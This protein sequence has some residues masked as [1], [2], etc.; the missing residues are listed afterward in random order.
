MIRKIIS[1]IF[2]NQTK[3][4]NNISILKNGFNQYKSIKLEKPIFIDNQAIPWYTY[5][6]IEYLMQFDYSDKKVLEFGSG[7]SSIFWSKRCKNL[8]S[9]EHNKDWY[10]T[11]KEKI[12]SNNSKLILTDENNYV[13]ICN[14]SD[15]FDIIIIDG[16]K[17]REC[18]EHVK[19]CIQTD[20]GIIILDNSDRYPKTSKFLRENLNLFEI[21]FFGFGPIN[22]YT[23]CT[24]IFISK[25]SKFKPLELQPNRGIGSLNENID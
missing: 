4:Y 7:N 14:K 11:V 20:T 5:P 10:N 23:W 9:I 18:A 6:A 17:R 22:N 1:R 16:I 25:N 8:T 24:S 12:N 15:K 13:N 2:K 3:F 19:N 21:D